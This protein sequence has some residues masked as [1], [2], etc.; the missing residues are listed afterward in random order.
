MSRF[1]YLELDETPIAPVAAPDAQ[2]TTHTHELNGARFGSDP[3][4][5]TA[6]AS[7]LVSSSHALAAKA[8]LDWDPKLA[9]L[10]V[11]GGVAVPESVG[12]AVVRSDTGK[13]IGIV[14]KRYTPIPH[15][16]LFDLADAIVGATDGA[17]RV[18]NAGHRD[19]GGRVFVQLSTQ[20][21]NVDG[22][23]GVA[24]NVSL[25][26]SHDG[27]CTFRAG[28]S[29]TVIV[30]RN[31]YARAFRDTAGGLA[32]RHTA[33]AETM[34]AQAVEVAKAAGEFAGQWTNAAIALMGRPFDLER[35]HALAS[36]LCPGEGTRSE[37]QRKALV[38]A[39]HRAPGAMPGTAWG[40]A[41]AVTYFTTHNAG[42]P[43][44]RADAAIFG[45]G[46]PADMQADAWWALADD[47]ATSDKRLATVKLYRC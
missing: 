17:M 9:A 26:T 39:W 6:R 19:G 35:M 5:L 34:I 43:E 44:S 38:S 28:F 31:T 16:R 18:G 11:A 45:T 4:A 46:S 14:G 36:H 30:C 23:G 24:L 40:A 3:D 27:S 29:S 22:I 25:F 32:I 37:N 7:G 2:V 20:P 12:R 47:T 15:R 33:S 42:R 10:V 8:D 41:Q 13:P 1:Q 21:E